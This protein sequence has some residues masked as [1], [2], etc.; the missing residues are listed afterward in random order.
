MILAA[1]TGPIPGSES[2]SA[3]V[4]WFRSIGP[5]RSH[6]RHCPH[7]PR[8]APRR[9]H[10]RG[11]RRVTERRPGR[12]R[13]AGPPG[14]GARR[15]DRWR[16]EGRIRRRRRSRRRLASL[17]GVGRLP[18]G[19]RRPGRR[20]EARARCSRR[21]GPDARCLQ[22]GGSSRGDRAV[23]ADGDGWIAP[24]RSDDKCDGG[25]HGRND[26]RRNRGNRDRSTLRRRA[27][28]VDRRPRRLGSMSPSS[29]RHGAAGPSIDL[30]TGGWQPRRG[31]R[32]TR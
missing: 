22:P 31:S 15:R 4:A 26:E 16:R 9:R 1:V 8:K 12:R 23:T 3:S 5:S 13:E 24:A 18:D 32:Q 6:C 14:S 27:R 11:G 10:Y 28:P 7:P 20:R 17:Y 2:S 29:T 25:E 30:S 21:P 19:R